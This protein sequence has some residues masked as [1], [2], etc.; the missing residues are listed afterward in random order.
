MRINI[1][2]VILVLSCIQ[3]TGQSSKVQG[4]ISKNGVILPFE[5]TIVFWEKSENTA[6]ALL[7]P[8]KLTEKERE[9]ILGGKEPFFVISSKD[10]P[11]TTK[12]KSW[13][14]YAKIEFKFKENK[15]PTKE[16]LQHIYIMA[17]GLEEQNFTDNLTIGFDYDEILSES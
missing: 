10:S 1:L 8:S 2:F 14:P 5:E 7:F 12:W 15:K 4:D 6:S 3:C 9:K 16:N 11:N 13:Y 17:Y